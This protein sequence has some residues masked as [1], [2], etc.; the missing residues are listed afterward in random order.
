MLGYAAV[1]NPSDVQPGYTP[2]SRVAGRTAPLAV[3][4]AT[5]PGIKNNLSA[6]VGYWYSPLRGLSFVAEPFVYDTSFALAATDKG[7][8]ASRNVSWGASLGSIFQF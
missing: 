7:H 3:N 4:L 6:H 2:A 8:V 5:A 1:L